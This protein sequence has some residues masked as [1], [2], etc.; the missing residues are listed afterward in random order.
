MQYEN[1]YSRGG[2]AGVWTAAK[3][4]NQ[5]ESGTDT[6]GIINTAIVLKALG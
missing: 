3:T 6:R 4:L 1:M 5:Y 2:G